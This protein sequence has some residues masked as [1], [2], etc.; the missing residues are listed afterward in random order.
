MRY[1][2]DS[3]VGMWASVAATPMV[4]PNVAELRRLFSRGQD[5][6]HTQV[7]SRFRGFRAFSS[8]DFSNTGKFDTVEDLTKTKAKLNALGSKAEASPPRPAREASA[9]AP[10]RL[11]KP[12]ARAV[13]MRLFIDNAPK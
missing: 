4:A 12:R 8:E 2:F 9:A 10:D 3:N 1:A 7:G 6:A 5:V 13:V 11:T